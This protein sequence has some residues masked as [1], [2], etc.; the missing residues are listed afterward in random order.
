[1]RVIVGAYC[2]RYASTTWERTP[3]VTWASFYPYISQRT[4]LDP[5]SAGGAREGDPFLLAQQDQLRSAI[6]LV[7]GCFVPINHSS[8]LS[9]WNFFPR[10]YVVHIVSSQGRLDI[11]IPDILA[12][13]ACVFSHIEGRGPHPT[14]LKIQP[15]VRW[16]PL[17]ENYFIDRAG[18]AVL[19]FW[20]PIDLSLFFIM[21]ELALFFFF[22]IDNT[23]PNT[24]LPGEGLS[25]CVRRHD[26][27]TS[28]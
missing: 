6:L 9:S 23:P 18:K 10:L 28:A 25:L 27:S 13:H 2:P 26:C 8:I 22:F 15:H 21:C 11:F 12:G 16:I 1:M 7:H 17:L 3:C 5:L 24:E 19:V 20:H 4:L 14:W